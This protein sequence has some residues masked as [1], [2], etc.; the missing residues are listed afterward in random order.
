MHSL[1]LG[2]EGDQADVLDVG[3]HGSRL[4][5][6]A[7]ASCPQWPRPGTSCSPLPGCLHRVNL[8]EVQP[9]ELSN[10]L[11]QTKH[12]V[13]CVE[14]S[15]AAHSIFLLPFLQLRPLGDSP[16]PAPLREAVASSAW[17]ESTHLSGT[18]RWWTW[19]PLGESF[20]GEDGKTGWGA[21][22]GRGKNPPRKTPQQS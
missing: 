1:I 20:L 14:P 5:G 16:S 4:A 22:L 21:Y 11:E 13:F 7:A 10:Y 18:A 8:W 15:P 2:R 6:K 12:F 3:W 9:R 17:A 19:R